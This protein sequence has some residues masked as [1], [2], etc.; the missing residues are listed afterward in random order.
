MLPV[1]KNLW[2]TGRSLLTASSGSH[3]LV[4]RTVHSMRRKRKRVSPCQLSHLRYCSAEGVEACTSDHLFFLWALAVISLL[5]RPGEPLDIL[6]GHSRSRMNLSWWETLALLSLVKD[7]V[8][9]AKIAPD[10]WFY[11]GLWCFE[12]S[13]FPGSGVQPNSIIN[14]SLIGTEDFTFIWA[15]FSCL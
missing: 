12:E 6:K 11:I 15:Q 8:L 9:H 7:A 3:I 5:T 10:T 2:K 4:I 1:G 14:V 13:S